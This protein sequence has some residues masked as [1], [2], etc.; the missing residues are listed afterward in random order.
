MTAEILT[1]N[2]APLY[3]QAQKIVDCLQ[4][5]GLVALPT[6][7]VYG[8]GASPLVPEAIE[9]LSILKQRKPESPFSLVVPT[10]EAAQ[11]IVLPWHRKVE[12]LF[13]RLCPGPITF[14]LPIRKEYFDS[15]KPIVTQACAPKGTAGVRIPDHP[16]T[17]EVLRLLGVPLLLS[18]ANHHGNP[19]P[20]DGKQ[21]IDDLQNEVDIICDAG[22]T[23]WKKSSTVVK[24]DGRIPTILREGALTAAQVRRISSNIVL[25]VCTG[26]TCRS[27]MAE[28]LFRKEMADQLKCD[29]DK[30][31]EKGWFVLSCGVAAI[32]GEPASELA[33][34]TMKERGLD[35][36]KHVSQNVSETLIRYADYIYTLT[37]SHRRTLVSLFPQ[38]ESRIRLVNPENVDIPDPYGGTLEFYQT[39]ARQIENAVHQRVITLLR[40][41][42]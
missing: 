37:E 2:S 6:E 16:L 35:L 13:R 39:C 5:G 34:I 20:I 31:E 42:N 29:P 21:V 12:K 1:F 33:K 40:N 25:F 19:D 14:V 30:L 24:F 9:R 18:S 26:N 11:K 36:S 27:P 32:S 28:T 3:Q 23:Y 17:L 22:P 8:V 38:A 10:T 7:T 4:S 41:D 15:F